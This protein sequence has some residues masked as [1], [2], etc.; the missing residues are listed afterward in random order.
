[1]GEKM[2]KRLGAPPKRFDIFLTGGCSEGLDGIQIFAVSGNLAHYVLLIV[3]S[4]EL[5]S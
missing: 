2:S 3:R 1:M 5:D 4:R